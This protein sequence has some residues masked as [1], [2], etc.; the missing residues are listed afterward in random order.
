MAGLVMAAGIVIPPDQ[1]ICR[2]YSLIQLCGSL[3]AV[4]LASY[5][6]F[7]LATTHDMNERNNAKNYIQGAVLGLIIIW[8]APLAIKTLIGGG[9]ICGW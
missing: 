8:I 5:A 9:D 4:L 7:T 1:P 6:G 3:G 2:L